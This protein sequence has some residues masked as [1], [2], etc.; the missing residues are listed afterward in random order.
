[1]GALKKVTTNTGLE[2][3][4]PLFINEGDKLKVDTR[5]G[6]YIERVR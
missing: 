2:L 1:T 3:M 5:D 6:R 4:V